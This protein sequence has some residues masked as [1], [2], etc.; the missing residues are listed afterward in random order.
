VEQIRELRRRHRLPFGEVQ[1][2]S[3][4]RGVGAVGFQ[5]RGRAGPGRENPTQAV[6]DLARLVN[7]TGHVAIAGV[8]AEKDLHPAPEGHPG[9]LV[10]EAVL[11][12]EFRP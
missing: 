3:A 5:A 1:M 10:P 6:R 2:D 7:P 8:Y 4:Q 11:E 9:A 12:A